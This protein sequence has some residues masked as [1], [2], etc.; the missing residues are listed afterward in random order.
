MMPITKDMVH[1]LIKLRKPISSKYTYGHAFL[2]AGSKGKMGA[3]VIAD[4]RMILHTT[5]PEALLIFREN[6]IAD[7]S[8]YTATG[9][10]PGI[11]ITKQSKQL[12]L[13]L[14]KVFKKPLVIDADA[15][16]I[17][18]TKKKLFKQIPPNTIITPH[19]KE[20]DR[21]FGVH[22]TT[23]QRINTA[24]AMAATYSIII[25]LKGHQTIITNGKQTFVNTTGNTG[26]AKAGSGD[27]LT[28]M[29]TSFLA[30]GYQSINAAII[31]VYLHG[32]AADITM[33]QQSMESM[34]ITDVIASIGKAFKA[35]V[36]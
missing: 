22:D 4:S 3:S 11:G 8:R 10:G 15:I 17:V 36:K 35:T 5:I 24:I 18:A 7:F 14:L 6:N 25:V 26:L 21:L 13:Y 20:F 33:Q 16:S 31:A 23:E 28:G 29:I 30:Q 19:Y 32:L 34:M 1:A 2:V 9:I 12:L 27:A